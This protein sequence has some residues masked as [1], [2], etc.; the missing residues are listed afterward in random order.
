MKET[1]HYTFDMAGRKDFD[2]MN[3]LSVR[4]IKDQ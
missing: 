2:V 1:L 3:G 4:C